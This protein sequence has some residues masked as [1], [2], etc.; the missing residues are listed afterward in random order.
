[1]KRWGCYK[2]DF[3]A[4]V[5]G[6]CMDTAFTVEINDNKYKDLIEASRNALENVKK[7]ITK[8]IEDLKLEK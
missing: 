5:N 8:N 7:I 4:Q 1:M 2:V 6:Y 3:G